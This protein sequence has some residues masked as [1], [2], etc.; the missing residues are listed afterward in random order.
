M[1]LQL[2]NI[3][4]DSDLDAKSDR[5]FGS[6]APQSPSPPPPPPLLGNWTKVRKIGLVKACFFLPKNLRLKQKYSNRQTIYCMHCYGQWII[7]INTR[8]LHS[9]NRSRIPAESIVNCFRKADKAVFLRRISNEV[10]M[11]ILTTHPELNDDEY[12][13]PDDSILDI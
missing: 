2:L 4:M 9:L 6:A 1:H 13:D 3:S 7:S 12:A 5:I 8:C 10:Y 11:M